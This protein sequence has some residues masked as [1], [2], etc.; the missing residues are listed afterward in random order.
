MREKSKNDIE[1]ARG[2][3]RN[4][5][6]WEKTTATTRAPLVMV[7]DDDIE[8]AKSDG[9]SNF[10]FDPKTRT[11]INSAIALCRVKKIEPIDV[12]PQPGRIRPK[13]SVP[14]KIGQLNEL[15]VKKARTQS[16]KPSG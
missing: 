14:N 11:M 4:K 5:R 13:S 1:T 2:L 6:I 3:N 16:A 12:D 9:N 8:A 7:R 15:V 10:L